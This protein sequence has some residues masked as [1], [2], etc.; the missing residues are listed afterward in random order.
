MR[1]WN[2]LRLPLGALLSVMACTF[3][4]LAHAQSADLTETLSSQGSFT[5]FA[6]GL[7][8][9]GLTDTLRSAGPYTV[10][11]P[12]D[13]A[14]ARLSPR[15]RAS[16]QDPSALKQVLQY[17]LAPGV[18]T[19]AQIVQVPNVRTVEGE[20]VKITAA[21]GG[22]RINDSQVIQPDLQAANGII[23]VIDAVLIPPSLVASLPNTGSAEPATWP[24]AVAGLGVAIAALGLAL[25]RIAVNPASAQVR[26]LA[27]PD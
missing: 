2:T 4:S 20:Q 19:A 26:D 8:T 15:V 23:H 21:D 24:F 5:Q 12:T 7:D 13:D 16:L 11:A 10:W 22:V 14:F 6:R 1:N 27:Q 17:H 25:R 9:A 3:P 18:V